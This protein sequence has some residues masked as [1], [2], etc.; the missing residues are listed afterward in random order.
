MIFVYFPS[1]SPCIFIYNFESNSLK[2]PLKIDSKEG[3]G[4]IILKIHE[5]KKIIDGRGGRKLKIYEMSLI[6]LCMFLK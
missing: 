1:N 2:I 6:C 4:D 3:W 5:Y